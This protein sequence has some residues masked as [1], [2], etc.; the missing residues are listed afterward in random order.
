MKRNIY[1]F[2]KGIQNAYQVLL[3]INKM[4]STTSPKIDVE[5]INIIYIDR[6]ELIYHGEMKEVEEENARN[7]EA[8]NKEVSNELTKNGFTPIK[9]SYM[10]IT[11][12]TTLPEYV[13]QTLRKEFPC[14]DDMAIVNL[15]LCD[16]PENENTPYYSHK[17]LKYFGEENCILYIN[18][19][20]DRDHHRFL[21][22]W[23]RIA[24]K[25][26]LNE[27]IDIYNRD[28]CLSGNA[29][30]ILFDDRFNEIFNRKETNS[31][32]IVKN[33]TL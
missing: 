10:Q 22:E 13:F 11:H 25:N 23:R 27:D 2:E 7:F 9:T 29:I 19:F 12:I 31:S 3:S 32:T 21:H 16:V 28:E 18:N 5:D 33:L 6:N 20:P 8:V 17:I 1:I 26:D 24:S 4:L 30:N 14:D 15:Y